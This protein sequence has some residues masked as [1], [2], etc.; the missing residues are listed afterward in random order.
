MRISDWSSDVCSSDLNP[1]GIVVAAGKD[2]IAD[3]EHG[4]ERYAAGALQ[5]R[6]A[7]RLVD[8]FA[9][10]VDRRCAAHV[11]RKPRQAPAKIAL[12]DF[13][14]R[15]VGIPFFLGIDRGGLAERR[16]GDL[17]PAVL[18]APQPEAGGDDE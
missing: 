18:D 16:K 3:E 10:D 2:R 12:N 5:F 15:K 13:S 1:D 17:A 8:P 14:L 7:I 9:R 11:D 6:Q 4:I